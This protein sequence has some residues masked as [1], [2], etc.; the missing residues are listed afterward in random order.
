MHAHHV[1]VVW[2]GFN[3]HTRTSPLARLVGRGLVL[4]DHSVTD[5]EWG[6]LPGAH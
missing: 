4:D 5:L 1:A 3:D 2:E 6:E